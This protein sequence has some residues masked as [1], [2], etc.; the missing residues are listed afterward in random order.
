LA[1][2][3]V[4]SLLLMACGSSSDETSTGTKAATADAGFPLTI[5]NCGRMLTFDAPPK[6]A[7][8]TF[9]PTLEPLLALGLEDSIAGREDYTEGP[10]LP[11]QEAAFK[12]IKTISKP[13]TFPTKEVMLSLR[14]DFVISDSLRNFDASQGAATVEELEAA[15]APVYIQT[16]RCEDGQNATFEDD[17]TDLTNLAKIFGV[18][19]R[20]APVIERMKAKIA[21]V[22]ERLKGTKPV[23]LIFYDYKMGPL[24]LM[25]RGL[26]QVVEFGGGDNLTVSNKRIEVD[27][28]VEKAVAQNPEVILLWDYGPEGNA[29][30]IKYL[31]SALKTTD[32]VKNNKLIPIEGAYTVPGYRTALGVEKVARILHP[33]RF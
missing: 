12:S 5:E 28:S 2:V 31:K 16:G 22:R 33:D 23:R 14:P 32:A 20:A 10:I 24:S 18:P 1:V 3:P 4:I 30:S 17:Y 29:E 15:G 7:I 11:E 25:T 21:E 13:S 26:S 27:V 8:T 6:R 9:Q 19:E